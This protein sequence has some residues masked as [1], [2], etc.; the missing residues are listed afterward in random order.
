MDRITPEDLD[1]QA[2]EFEQRLQ[3]ELY[4]VTRLFGQALNTSIRVVATEIEQDALKKYGRD[5]IKARRVA[6]QLAELKKDVNEQIDEFEDVVFPYRDAQSFPSWGEIFMNL[7]KSH[8][9]EAYRAEAQRRRSSVVSEIDSKTNVRVE[10]DT[11]STKGLF[12]AALRERVFCRQIENEFNDEGVEVEFSNEDQI[13]DLKQYEQAVS[14]LE[15]AQSSANRALKAFT[16]GLQESIPE[17]SVYTWDRIFDVLAVNVIENAK[18]D[19]LA[20]V[21][22]IYGG[23]RVMQ[24]GILM[25]AR[26]N[27]TPAIANTYYDEELAEIIDMQEWRH[28]RDDK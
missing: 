5:R 20:E 19:D 12:S 10:I 23:D 8:V 26:R 6:N 9:G 25:K 28:Q 21:I 3:V 18:K 11:S 17:E 4:D 15:M 22:R 1:Q 7:A 24:P 16:D 13:V 27:M 2:S 14:R